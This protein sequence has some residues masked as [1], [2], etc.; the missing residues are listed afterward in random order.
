M[1]TIRRAAVTG[2]LAAWLAP[3]PVLAESQSS[4]SSS[5]CSDGRCSRVERYVVED[6]RGRA[7]FTRVERWIEGVPGFREEQARSWRHGNRLGVPWFQPRRANRDDDGDD[8]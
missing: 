7:G 1:T 6:E 5:N 3:L 2:L 4:N 8:D